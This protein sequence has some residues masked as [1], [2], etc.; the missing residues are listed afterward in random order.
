[1]D[2]TSSATTIAPPLPRGPRA[3]VKG[4]HGTLTQDD[5]DQTMD[6]RQAEIDRCIEQARRR[7][8]W[9]SGEIQFSF[10][11]A[12]HGGVVAVHPTSSS[13]GHRDLERCLADLLVATTFP[14]PAGGTEATF[15]WG[16][17]FAPQNGRTL[18]DGDPKAL[19]RV[20]RKRV[21][22]LF[23]TCE[24]RRGRNR[25]LV[26][27]YV[28]VSGRWLS[29]GAVPLPASADDKVDCVL[30]ELLKLRL[31]KRKR[32]AKLSFELR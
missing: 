21:P 15:T 22:K 6:A 18:D 8:R 10:R 29:A 7:L 25:F 5:V 12:G 32:A 4:L 24:V 31:P 9:L 3:S 19:A 13:I 2:A 11:V 17:R 30:A 16:M 23:R 20:L 27:A 14:K 1:V 28:A 26:T